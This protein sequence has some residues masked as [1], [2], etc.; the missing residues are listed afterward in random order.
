MDVVFQIP[1]ARLVQSEP[2]TE[3]GH[4]LWP[5][6]QVEETDSTAEELPEGTPDFSRELLVALTWIEL[7]SNDS[8]LLLVSV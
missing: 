3:E 6:V 8:E 2:V 5:E 7:G 1:V 4:P